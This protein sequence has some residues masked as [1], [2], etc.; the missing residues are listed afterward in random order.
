MYKMKFCI[1]EELHDRHYRHHHH[2]DLHFHC[3]TAEETIR[4]HHLLFRL[5]FE[6]VLNQQNIVP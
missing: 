1:P 2:Q 6:H 5:G 4:N 3:T